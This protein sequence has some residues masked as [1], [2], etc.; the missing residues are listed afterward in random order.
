[1]STQSAEP[2]LD[3][4]TVPACPVTS[5]AP[6]C[7]FS[8]SGYDPTDPRFDLDTTG[9]YQHLQHISEDNGLLRWTEGGGWIATSY[10]A[11]HEVMLHPKLTTS[12]A[13]HPFFG[14]LVDPESEDPFFRIAASSLFG[15]GTEQYTR[16]RRHI[17]R[18]FTKMAVGKFD[19]VIA[20]MVDDLLDSIIGDSNPGDRIE[21]DWTARVAK[22]LPYRVV[23]KLFGIPDDRLDE[24]VP[25]ASK[26]GAVVNPAITAEMFDDLQSAVLAFNDLSTELLDESL[27]NPVTPAVDG[28]GN[29]FTQLAEL[30]QSGE[31][32]NDE[33]VA[34]AVALLIGGI[35]T[36]VNMFNAIILSLAGNP[37]VQARL[38]APGGQAMVPAF[39]AETMRVTPIGKQSAAR[40]ATEDL[41]LCGQEIKKGETVLA[42]VSSANADETVFP[43]NRRFDVER[44]NL[45]QSLIFGK[46]MHRC[47]G[48]QL[49]E[50]EATVATE[51]VVARLGDITV[52]EVAWMAHPV[53]H[54][55][56]KAVISAT[57]KPRTEAVS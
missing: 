30:R 2:L 9:Y 47:I 1:M 36:S 15:A 8:G 17:S 20:V 55:A 57:V 56:S 29:L 11:N 49:A 50:L 45:H 52:T 54:T 48:A 24:Y 26:I 13:Y 23:A 43:D 34:I 40:Y 12:I 14:E 25:L 53:F 46:G 35:E 27:V 44:D 3:E 31:L 28:A 42:M 22:E 4:E 41:V 19:A 7:P 21:F 39:V 37:G 18:S 33:C 10:A 5:T 6:T 16:L 38:G 51:R 32:T